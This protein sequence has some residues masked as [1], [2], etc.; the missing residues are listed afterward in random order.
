M[1]IGEEE[2]HIFWEPEGSP[3]DWRIVCKGA[4]QEIILQEDVPNYVT[5][6]TRTL[7]LSLE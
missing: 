5:W 1:H 6:T 2:R 4:C 3:L 7:K